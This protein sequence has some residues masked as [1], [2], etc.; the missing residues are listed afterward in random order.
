MAI[1]TCTSSVPFI[2]V[3]LPLYSSRLAFPALPRQSSPIFP[4]EPAELVTNE[5]RDR[6]RLISVR[7][8][9]GH[10][11]GIWAC[12]RNNK[13]SRRVRTK[14]IVAIT[15]FT[16]KGLENLRAKRQ[17]PPYYAVGDGKR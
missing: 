12:R 9:L 11:G 17:G 15:G 1:R 16:E 3:A 10:G 8:F 14:G 7:D 2:W 5:I 6:N 13:M 4:R